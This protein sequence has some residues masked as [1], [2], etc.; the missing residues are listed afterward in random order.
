MDYF[1][2]DYIVQ[3]ELPIVT[4]I[5]PTLDERT[6]MAERAKLLAQQQDYKGEIEH[7][8]MTGRAYSLG[9]KRNRLC[10]SAKGSIICH[11]DDDDIIAPDWVTK[12]VEH[13]IKTGADI[14]GLSSAYFYNGQLRDFRWNGSQPY[15]L[16][17]TMCYH[18]HVWERKPFPDL[19]SGEDTE[20]QKHMR[21]V[22]HFY[23]HSFLA[24]LHG[25]NTA[26][27]KN[28]ALYKKTNLNPAEIYPFV[29]F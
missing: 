29:E 28:M 3:G 17:A 4:V 21:V 26:S 25:N 22:P 7:L 20:F 9:E 10:N 2:P 12:S 8:W 23:K 13:L 1:K 5:T 19:P 6:A 15:V 14:T 24:T 16:G 27:H 11:L 18:K